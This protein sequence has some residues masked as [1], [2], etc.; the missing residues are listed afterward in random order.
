MSYPYWLFWSG[1]K[2]GQRRLAVAARED[3][4]ANAV[5]RVRNA[6]PSYG[7]RAPSCGLG[8]AARSPPR[9]SMYRNNRAPGRLL[10]LRKKKTAAHQ[11]PPSLSI[12]TPAASAGRRTASPLLV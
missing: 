2:L 4:A 12:P 1:A 10:A 3:R 6:F 8:T 7:S 9:S 5:Q 11:E